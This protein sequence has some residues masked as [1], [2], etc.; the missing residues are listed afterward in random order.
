VR[1]LRKRDLGKP[2]CVRILDH[3]EGG[4]GGKVMAADVYGI[5]V[6]YDRGQIILRSWVC[7]D[8]GKEDPDNQKDF[9]LVRSAVV[10]ITHLVVAP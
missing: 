2:L 10:G 7:H 6:A 4:A 5:L 1:P 8:G 9:A 3:F